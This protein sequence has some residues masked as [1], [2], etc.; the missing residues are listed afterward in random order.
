MISDASL[1]L[2]GP[3]HPLIASDLDPSEPLILGV[4]L[5]RLVSLVL[6]F[7]PDFLIPWEPVLSGPLEAPAFFASSALAF[8]SEGGC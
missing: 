3:Y 7:F 2:V 1:N 8:A 4:T 5:S 6:Y